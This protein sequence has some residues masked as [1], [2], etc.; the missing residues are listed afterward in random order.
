M[1]S[2]TEVSLIVEA[3][4]R[5]AAEGIGV[6]LVSFPS[7]ELF[8]SQEQSYRQSVLLPA[9]KARLAV[10]AGVAQGWERWV[11]EGGATITLD[12]FGAS[13]PYERIYQEFGFTAE[14]VVEKSLKLI[15]IKSVT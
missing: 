4:A 9:V 3:G 7:W 2:G 1:A 8:E 10:E 14:H 12:R 5:L 6:R 11:G 13:A 15:H